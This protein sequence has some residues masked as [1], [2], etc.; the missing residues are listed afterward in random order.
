GYISKGQDEGGKLLFGGKR[1]SIFGH[2]NGFFLEPT[3]ISTD[4]EDSVIVKEEI[5]GPVFPLRTFSSYD[6][7]IE[8][9]NAVIYGLGSSVWTKDVTRAL[10]ATRDLR[11]GTVWVNDHVPVPSEMPWPA[12]KQSGHG[13]S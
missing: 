12:W 6:E 11:F 13:A 10:R 8:R 4:N 7:V 5:F 9:S 1:P 3:V 2:E